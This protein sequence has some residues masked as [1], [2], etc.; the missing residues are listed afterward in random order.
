MAEKFNSKNLRWPSK[1]ML[2]QKG[3]EHIAKE[4]QQGGNSQ[5]VSELMAM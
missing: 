4:S 5:N 2:S 1:Q 3:G